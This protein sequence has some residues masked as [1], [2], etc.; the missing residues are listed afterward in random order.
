M[1]E[2]DSFIEKRF[3][4]FRPQFGDD[5]EFMKRLNQ[6]LKA[7]E[8]MKQMR[9]RDIRKSKYMVLVAFIAGILVGG[10]IMIFMLT[11]PMMQP[12]IT[13][14]SDMKFLVMIEQ[15]INL[16]CMLVVGG[17]I[18]FEAVEVC[19]MILNLKIYKESKLRS[20]N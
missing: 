8:Y 14:G 2:K 1:M 13:F 18:V 6:K 7:V 12:I 10:G 15:H 19:E 11:H 17:L 20:E 9:D 16:L 5:K 4:E 3:D